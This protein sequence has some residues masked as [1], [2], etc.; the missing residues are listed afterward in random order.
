LGVSY[1][2]AWSQLRRAVAKVDRKGGTT[3]DAARWQQY[4]VLMRIVDQAFVAFEK[5]AG[6]GEKEMTWHTIQSRDGWG[7]LGLSGKR[8]TH[9]VRKDAAWEDAAMDRIYDD[10]RAEFDLADRYAA[11][12]SK[13]RSIQEALELVLDV[14]RDRRLLLLEV[15][16]VVL[17]LEELIFSALRLRCL[18]EPRPLRCRRPRRH[19]GRTVSSPSLKTIAAT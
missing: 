19:A 15:A 7:K 16:V 9:H 4:L 17:I 14:A 10:L 12:E 18:R 3:L 2:K 11:M 1:G 13:L 6:E 5:S 8:V